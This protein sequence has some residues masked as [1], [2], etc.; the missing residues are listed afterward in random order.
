MCCGHS[1]GLRRTEVGLVMSDAPAL[2]LGDGR[3]RELAPFLC[4]LQA[5]CGHRAPGC[6]DG[7]QWAVGGPQRR[8]SRGPFLAP[9]PRAGAPDSAGV[10]PSCGPPPSSLDLQ[11]TRLAWLFS[12]STCLC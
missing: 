11:V 2:A 12:S 5:G 7:P 9:W 10:C 1:R 3:S 6:G 4:W 8:G